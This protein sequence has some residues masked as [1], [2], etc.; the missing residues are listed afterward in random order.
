MILKAFPK[1]SHPLINL[2]TKRQNWGKNSEK[3]KV[4]TA[5]SLLNP[6]ASILKFF[7]YVHAWTSDANILHLDQKTMKYMT[8]KW[9]CGKF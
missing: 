7:F 4:K 9:L 2:P 3:K 5:M 1:T 8:C 6:K